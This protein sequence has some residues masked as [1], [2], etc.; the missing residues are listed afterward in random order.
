MPGYVT[1][2]IFGRDI[3]DHLKDSLLKQNLYINRAVYSL[4]Q[5]GPD[6]FFYY[7][8][9]YVLHGH[10]LGHMA[11]AQNTNQFFASLLESRNDFKLKKD[12][13]IADAYLAGF[14]G[15]YILDTTCH[16]FI[17]GR[18]HFDGRTNDYFARHAYLETDIDTALLKIKLHRSR[19]DFHAENTIQL[20]LRQQRVVAHMLHYAYR[21]T[22]NG[23]WVSRYTIFMAIFATQLGFRIL[24]DE[25][26]QKKVLFRLAEKLFLG[27]PV[28]SPLIASDTLHFRTDP[29]NLQHKKW[30]NPWDTSLVSKE[31]FFDLYRKSA[32]LYCSRL[33]ELMLLLNQH[34]HSKKEQL[35]RDHFLAD[36]G[37]L[38][39]HS[40][41]D[42]SIPT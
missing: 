5:Q 13:K 25:T 32:N 41:L 7:L 14:L 12:R 30:K 11:H 26:G 10:N 42:A 31:S 15:H 4:G 38:S 8:P 2:Y 21:H 22:Y 29:F 6:I 9:A 20:T 16:P 19:H 23:L 33:K 27:Y 3:Y 34:P 39:F 37:N 24:Y 40:G 1:H 28:F 17:Y 35:L 18:T 36:Y